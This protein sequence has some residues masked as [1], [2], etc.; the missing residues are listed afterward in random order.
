MARIGDMSKK[1]LVIGCSG[2]IGS[3]LTVLLLEYGFVVY[4]VSGSTPCTID[5]KNHFCRKI[6]LLNSTTSLNLGEFKPDILVHTAWVTTPGVFWES[7]INYDWVKVSKKIIQEFEQSGGKYLLVT[8]TCAEYSWESMQPLSEIS[9]A[10]PVSNYG[11]SKLELFNWV[12]GTT[13]PFLWT[14]TFFQF[15]L[16]E[17]NGRLI[18]T[19]IDSLLAGNEFVIRNSS[20]VRDFVYIEDVVKIIYKLIIQEQLGVINIGRGVGIDI[21]SVTKTITDLIGRED[22]LRYENSSHPKSIVVSNPKNL[23]SAV[24]DHSWTSFDSAIFATINSRSSKR[25]Y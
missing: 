18:P 24:G 17:P 6:D 13:I 10:S 1:V 25:F 23:L 21:R 4:G 9:E 11:K 7:P 2:Q 5:D 16:N 8:S 14:R 3:R 20:D 12:S 19:L 15:G 22:L